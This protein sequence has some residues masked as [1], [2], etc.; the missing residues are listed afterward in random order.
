MSDT[1]TR[2]RRNAMAALKPPPRLSL[3]DWI[4]GTMRLPEGVSA[5]PGRV[6]LW[7]YQ[8]G[9]AEAISD[10][11]IERVTV[12][13]PVRVGLSEADAT[14]ARLVVDANGLEEHRQHWQQGAAKSTWRRARLR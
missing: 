13:K 5:T 10:P 14:A 2:T 4:E 9:I 6:T 12:V 3:P 7:P 11:L 1:L 8:R